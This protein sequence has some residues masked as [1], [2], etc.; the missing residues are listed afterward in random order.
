MFSFDHV[1]VACWDAQSVCRFVETELGG[2][3]L[4][5]SSANS[6][7]PMRIHVYTLAKRAKLELISPPAEDD[8]TFITKFLKKQGRVLHHLTFRVGSTRAHL[9]SVLRRAE[10]LGFKATGLRYHPYGDSWCE[11]FVSP[12][13]ARQLGLLI[14]IVVFERDDPID[15]AVNTAALKHWHARSP[16]APARREPLVMD[17]VCLAHT[18]V[19]ESIFGDLLEGK[20]RSDDDS[21]H[22]KDSPLCIRLVRN[23]AAP[24]ISVAHPLP[25]ALPGFSENFVAHHHAKL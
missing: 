13:S 20:R 16:P 4:A 17:A 7:T 14:Q 1:A 2:V 23:L 6:S 21:F 5:C 19:A 9:Q 15:E 10:D 3:R 18:P 22:W 24:V 11:F 8:T 25:A 12:S